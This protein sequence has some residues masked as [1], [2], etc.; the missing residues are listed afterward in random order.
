M[1]KKVMHAILN[2]GEHF[3]AFRVNTSTTV[4]EL[5]HFS[6]KQWSTSSSTANSCVTESPKFVKVVDHDADKAKPLISEEWLYIF[7]KIGREFMGGV[8]A[9]RLV[10]DKYKMATGYK[11]SIL[12]NDKSTRFIA[13]C[14]EVGCCWRIHFGPVNGD[15][16]RFVLKD[17]NVLHSNDGLGNPGVVGDKT[18][19][20]VPQYDEALVVDAVEKT[21]GSNIK[22]HHARKG[23]KTVFEQQFGD[24]EKSCSDLAWYV[25]AIEETNLDSYVKFEVDYATERFQRIFICFGACKHIYRYLRPVIY[26]YATFLTGRFMGALMAA[27][28]VNGNNG[29]Y[30]YDF[31][32]VSAKNKENWFWFL[33]NLKQVVDGRPIVFLSDRGEG[34]LQGIPKVFP[35]SY[36][37]YCFYHIKCN[38]PIRSGDANSKAI[39][40]LF[41]KAAYSYYTTTKFEESLRGMHAIECG[42]VANYVRAIPKE[43]WANAFF[44]ICR[45]NTH[46]STLSESF[47]N[48][49]VDLKKLFACSP[50]CDTFEIMKKNSTRRVEG[51]ETFNTRLTPIYEALL[52]ENIDI[53]HTWSV[54][55]SMER[56]YE[57][58]SPRSYFV[59]LL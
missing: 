35:D 43:K 15:I 20:S 44:P 48:W 37:N 36:H 51:L 53:G 26:L 58:H 12:K 41:H 38:L 45:Y 42:H 47:N 18:S 31:S 33:D 14:Q 11:I 5:K 52:K 10:V 39:I 40:D 2:H 16:S 24:D 46:S 59:D 32:L 6:C 25:K 23:K 1:S 13:K 54:S 30:P 8:K 21:Y 55:E 56:L 3:A 29:F 9:V 57:V 28:C 50:R 19:L 27:T 49:I 4:D 7:D 34:L 22:Y 17:V